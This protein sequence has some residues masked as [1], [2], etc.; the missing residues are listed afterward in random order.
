ML[1]REPFGF[2]HNLSELDLF[3]PDSL[4]ALAEKYAAHPSDYFVAGGAPSPAVE[5]YS[6]P[7]PDLS[8]RQGF[9]HLDSGGCR[10]LLKR[11]ENHDPRF[12]ALLDALFQQVVELRG[13]LGRERVVRLQSTI[14]I[15]S[16]STIT[17]FHFDPE[18]NFFAQIEGEKI[19]HVFSPSVVT[20]PELERFYVRG[21]VNI[22][23]VQ[24]RGR[25]PAREHIFTLGPGKG[26][27]HPQNAPHWV[28][29]CR[30]RSI[31]Y[32]FVYETD[33]TRAQGRVRACNYYLRK[34]R[35]N[36]AP[37]GCR[38]MRERLKSGTMRAIIPVRKAIVK[39]LETILETI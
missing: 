10:I 34:F 35:L 22:G 9:D 31:S 28:E 7:R 30:S 6:V 2:S 3:E 23:Q 13:G 18:I 1:G 20:E 19:Y 27:Y 37:P 32:G 5:F 24:L 38:R 21:V 39:V 36:P 4:R 14:L 16:A 11:P 17:P 8:P 25:D 29:T 12:R 15:S 26:L 33:A